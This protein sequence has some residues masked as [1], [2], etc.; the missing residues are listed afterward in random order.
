MWLAIWTAKYANDKP[1]EELIRFIPSVNISLIWNA[2][3]Q[4]F[5]LI[6]QH[7]FWEVRNGRTAR[8]WTNAWNQVP[9]LNDILNIPPN[10]IGEAQQHNKI[11]EYWAEEQEQGFRK[12]KQVPSLSE[13]WNTHSQKNWKRSYA[14]EASDIQ[15][16][17]TFYNGVIDLRG[18]SPLQRPTKSCTQTQPP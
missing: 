2:T 6:Q 14:K 17:E 12:W 5:Q 15:K 7:S 9:K 18:H 3:K 13:T 16:T 4:H 8:F 11:W 10:F 1:Q